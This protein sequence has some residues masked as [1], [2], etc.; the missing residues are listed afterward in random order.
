MSHC[1][2]SMLLVGDFP[3]DV[4]FSDVADIAELVV[5]GV[6]VEVAWRVDAAA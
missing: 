2:A 6:V 1:V 4:L 3:D 5:V